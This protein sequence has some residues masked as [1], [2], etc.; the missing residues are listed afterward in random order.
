MKRII[1]S[2]GLLAVLALTWS[3]AASD[4]AARKLARGKYLV[5]NVGM[6]ADCHSPRN[7]KGEHDP[8]RWLRGSVLDIVPA[9][10]L[11]STVWADAA[12]WIAG[13]PS[14]SEAD[15]VSLL[16]TGKTTTGA[17]KRAPMPPYRFS[18]QDAEAVVAYL[19]TLEVKQ[20]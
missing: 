18:Q 19:K 15:A 6:C 1:L 2:V 10:P 13:L 9:Q 11:P 17:T 20:S 12:P 3:C 14:I 7:D 16:S 4:P 8:A 5:E